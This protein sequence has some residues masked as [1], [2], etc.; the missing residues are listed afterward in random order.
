MVHI[1]RVKLTHNTGVANALREMLIA[2]VVSKASELVLN[3]LGKWRI[4]DV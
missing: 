2:G 3:R 4:I 1:G